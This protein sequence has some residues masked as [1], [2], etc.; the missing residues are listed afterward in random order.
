MK[1]T[2][3]FTIL[4]LVSYT[5]MWSQETK[6]TRIPLIG[7]MAPEFT[8]EST[9][10][11]LHFPDDYYMKWKILFSHPAD[12][13]S[14][15]SSE[16][17]ELAAMQDEF[18]KLNTKIV[19]ISTDGLNSHMEWVRS[20]ETVNYKGRDPL[21]IKF[22]LVSDRNLEIS[23]KY[24]MIHSYTSSTRDVR[25]VF[26]IDPSD[27]IC[28]IFFYPFDVGRNM[29]E[30]K[31]ALIALQLAEEKKVLIPANWMPGQDVMIPAPKTTSEAE[32]L[33]KKNDPDLYSITWYMW[34]KKLK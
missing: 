1:K 4:F 28:A 27:K 21:K 16:I 10:G 29:E 23:K 2:I 5:Q 30:I 3:C 25:G 9:M 32:S 11:K 7:E 19:V 13:T 24:G 33:A 17:L 34:F 14:V 26:I 22:P 8:A 12:F 31:R 20:M 6:D 18:N 15:C